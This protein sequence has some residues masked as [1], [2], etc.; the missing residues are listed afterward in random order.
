[1]AT[2]LA[3]DNLKEYF[4]I[5]SKT[6]STTQDGYLYSGATPIGYRNPMW[7][8]YHV[9]LAGIQDAALNDNNADCISLM[10]GFF[11]REYVKN[12]TGSDFT[13][14]LNYAPQLKNSYTLDDGKTYAMHPDVL[15]FVLAKA[16]EEDV[17]L[18]VVDQTEWLS[19]GSS[20]IF[21]S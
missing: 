21:W 13:F 11:C 10:S 19:S 9:S 3:L 8:V 14:E 1:M 16:E 6:L 20:Q 4:S 18:E 7:S 12:D 17:D 2:Q 5:L 15:K